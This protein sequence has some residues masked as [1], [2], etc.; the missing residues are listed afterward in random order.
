METDVWWGWVKAVVYAKSEHLPKWWLPRA[1]AGCAVCFVTLPCSIET[2]F[3]GRAHTG[4]DAHMQ[5]AHL[6]RNSCVCRKPVALPIS[7]IIAVVLQG[8]LFGGREMFFWAFKMVVLLLAVYLCQ[9]IHRFILQF[10]IVEGMWRLEILSVD[11]ISRT[12]LTLWDRFLS[13]FEEIE[14][15]TKIKCCGKSWLVSLRCVLGCQLNQAPTSLTSMIWPR[16]PVR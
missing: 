1:A 7:K 6:F 8:F 5:L 2:G 10:R 4:A 3:C 13:T 9:N 16:S 11:M 14:W 15:W 12:F